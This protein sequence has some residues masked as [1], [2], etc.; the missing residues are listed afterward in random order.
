MI[1]SD[2]S[3]ATSGPAV[4]HLRI[5]RRREQSQ[6]R[7]PDTFLKCPLFIA[8]LLYSDTEGDEYDL[9]GTGFWV[10]YPSGFNSASYLYLV[11][12]KHVID[13]LKGRKVVALVNRR[14]G[15]IEVLSVPEEFWYFHPSDDTVD[16]A[17]QPATIHPH[18]DFIAVGTE[19]FLSSE[20]RSRHN[21][22]IGDDTFTVGLFTYHAGTQRNMPIVR[23]GNIAMMPDEPIQVEG[24]FSEVYLVE[25]RSIGGLSGSPVLVRKT[26]TVA[27]TSQHKDDKKLDGLGQLF[28]LGMMRGHW[29][30]KESEMNKPSFVHDR[31]RG[32]NLGIGMVTPASKILEVINHPDLVAIA[33]SA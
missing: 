32:V 7:I 23:Y 24:G 11:T 4:G 10:A 25:A 2:P 9:Q 18:L 31:Q 20:L 27:I 5:P 3:H 12:A 16:V 30:I 1:L 26:V 13:D 19:R 22:G 28:L 29:D 8:E 17:V 21:I 33:G 14:D 15:G 6:L